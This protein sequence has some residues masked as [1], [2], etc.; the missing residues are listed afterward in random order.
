MYKDKYIKYKKKYLKLKEQIG[1]AQIYKYTEYDKLFKQKGSDT[2]IDNV[3]D[4]LAT[5]NLFFIKSNNNHISPTYGMYI[6][7]KYK[8]NNTEKHIRKDTQ[9]ADAVLK[10]I[11]EY[12]DNIFIGMNTSTDLKSLDTLNN[13]T[14][15]DFIDHSG[16]VKKRTT[17]SINDQNGYKYESIT[18]DKLWEYIVKNKIL[19]YSGNAELDECIRSAE[20]IIK[21]YET[22][23]TNIF[24]FQ[25]NDQS[26]DQSN[27]LKKINCLQKDNNPIQCR[28]ATN[29]VI[30]NNKKNDSL[31]YKFFKCY[32]GQ[33]NREQSNTLQFC[34]ETKD[35]TDAVY[36]ENAKTPKHAFI[37]GRRCF[38]MY[39]ISRLSQTDQAVRE[40][41][42]ILFNSVKKVKDDIHITLFAFDINIDYPGILDFVKSEPFRIDIRNA[43]NNTLDL[44]KLIHERNTYKI[45]SNFYGKQYTLK[46]KEKIKE[47]R[48]LIYTSIYTS[49]NKFLDGV[50]TEEK[51]VTSPFPFTYYSLNGKRVFAVQ[52]FHMDEME[53]LSHI[54]IITLRGRESLQNKNPELYN[55]II[56]TDETKTK[57]ILYNYISN[58][59]ITYLSNNN[60]LNKN[61]KLRKGVMPFEDFKLE[62]GKLKISLDRNRADLNWE[63]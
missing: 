31:K 18:L 2:P 54:S 34:V 50:V 41:R 59:M 61:R 29:N 30:C 26:N 58:N 15:L 63:I 32:N 55:Q 13:M 49:I 22:K 21:S 24:L 56:N 43:Y 37:N 11:T 33:N 48:R 45:L 60:K 38:I 40:R 52:S 47:F 14:I 20:I 17:S 16:Y 36:C 53:W 7:P 39:N 6:I 1:G 25:S 62:G 9:S 51:V 8:L 44:T 42:D 19:K 3:F 12:T 27:Y 28:L 35:T 10:I 23:D 4:F 57:Q 46:N 5:K